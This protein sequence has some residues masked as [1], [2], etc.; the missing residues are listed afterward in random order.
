MTAA[1]ADAAAGVDILLLTGPAGV[2]KSTLSWEIS[3]RLAAAGIAHAAIE[4][5]ELDRVHPKPTREELARLWPGT[6]D[7]SAVNLAALWATY[8]RLGHRRLILSGVMLHLGFDRR[9]IAGAIPDARIVVIR[10]MVDDASLVDR[11]D[12]RETGAGRDEQVERSLQQ[13]RRLRDE[14]QDGL[15]AIDTSGRRPA[16]VAETV[17]DRIGWLPAA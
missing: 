8:A 9:W 17:L 11:L 1:S 15:I 14:A 3:A 5:D 13:S 7:I 16:D 6:I 2:G 4:T 10:L 12:R